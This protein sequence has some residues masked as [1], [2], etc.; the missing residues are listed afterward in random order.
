M[1]SDKID[2]VIQLLKRM[3]VEFV[4]QTVR[5]GGIAVRQV[6]Q[7]VSTEVRECVPGVFS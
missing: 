1:Q 3:G 2:S 6:R 5:E 4:T 7:Q